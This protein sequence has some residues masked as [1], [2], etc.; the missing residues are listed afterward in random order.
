MGG[1]SCF[2]ILFNKSINYVV[3]Q[4]PKTCIYHQP[5]PG[6]KD[7]SNNSSVFS[8][9]L[10]G[11]LATRTYQETA[12]LLS[13]QD[14]SPRAKLHA[15]VIPKRFVRNVYSLTPDDANLIR[16][17]RQMGLE[18]MEKQQPQ[19]LVDDDYILCFHI[20]PFNSVDHL[21]LHVLAPASEMNYLYRYGKYNTG[22]RWCIGALEVIERLK[23]G[24]LAVPYKQLF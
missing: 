16:D 11:D 6:V 18:L 24:Q 22:A 15:L 14:I 17:M 1:L 2:Q 9:I 7:Y 10:R 4:P 19:A 13:F 3:D 21:H 12:E 8:K 5:P 20:P 23:G